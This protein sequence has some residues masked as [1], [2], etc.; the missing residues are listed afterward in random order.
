MET[1]VER[2]NQKQPA[3]IVDNEQEAAINQLFMRSFD[4]YIPTARY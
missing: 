3:L 2:C 4:L 1:L